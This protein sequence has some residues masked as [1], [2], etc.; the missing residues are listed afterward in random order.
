MELCPYLVFDGQCAAAF[1]FYAQAL[2]G[3]IESMQTFGESPMPERE[4]PEWRDRMLHARLS[5]GG[6]V[7]M[8]SDSPP[9]RHD[10]PQGF[11]VSLS[12]DSPAEAERIFQALAAGGTVQ[13]AI[14]ETFW[15]SRFGMLTDRFGIPWIVN[16]DRPAGPSV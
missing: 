8:G 16:C 2:G 14:Q 6:Q 1:R 13:M 12:V 11:S 7:L 15:A 10:R 4:A 3:T 5:V 9:D